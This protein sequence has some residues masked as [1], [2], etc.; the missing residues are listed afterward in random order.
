MNKSI[1]V[2][3]IT[4]ISISSYAQQPQKWVKLIKDYP[5]DH[6]TEGAFDFDSVGNIYVPTFLRTQRSIIYILDKYGNTINKKHF[7]SSNFNSEIVKCIVDRNRITLLGVNDYHTLNNKSWPPQLIA[8]NYC[9][10]IIIY[11]IEELRNLL[12]KNREWKVS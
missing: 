5:S 9:G 7:L 1:Y 6:M 4:L 2:C 3:V 10:N 12:S 11:I 8:M